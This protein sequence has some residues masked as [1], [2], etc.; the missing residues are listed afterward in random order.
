LPGEDALSDWIS[1]FIEHTGHFGIA[2]LIFAENVFPPIP[3]ELIIALAGFTAARG[4]SDIVGAVSVGPIRVGL[5]DRYS[6]RR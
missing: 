6:D 1:G 3:S 5:G 2:L 4:N